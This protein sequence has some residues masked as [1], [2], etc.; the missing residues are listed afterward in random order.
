MTEIN[1]VIAPIWMEARTRFTDP[2][3]SYARPPGSRTSTITS[4]IR[5]STFLS[6]RL[7]S[8]NLTDVET[9]YTAFR[10]EIIRNMIVTSAGLG[11]EIELTAKVAKL[12]CAVYR[13]RPNV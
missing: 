11:F 1:D 4:Q 6:N 5:G 7:T 13:S 9:G 8:V 2:V 12:H 10:G 3:S